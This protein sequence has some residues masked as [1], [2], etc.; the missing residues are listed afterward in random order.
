VSEPTRV[1]SCPVCR[2]LDLISVECP[3]GGHA[4]VKCRT[5][6]HVTID[7]VQGCDEANERVQMESFGDSFSRRSGPFVALYDSINA[8]RLIRSLD[9]R[10][11]SRVLEIGPGSGAVLDALAKL[12][13][14]V[15]G[16]DLSPAI[17]ERI[18][19]DFAIPVLIGKLETLPVGDLRHSFDVVVMRQVLEHFTDPR[20]ALASA[21]SLLKPNGKIYVAV[22]N[23]RSWQARFRG[24]AGYA[25]Y[26]VQ[27]FD[28]A[29]LRHALTAESF[30]VTYAES[31]EPISSWPNTLLRS[32]IG[33]GSRRNDRCG[34]RGDPLA[35]K[36]ILL[37]LSRLAAGLAIS[38]LRWLQA[39]LGFGDELVVIARAR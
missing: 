24:W 16:L 38:P 34:Y 4:L 18:M 26:H 1:Q 27:Y 11:R 19:S 3:F 13:H 33:G 37:E 39:A 6:G 23:M 12:G 31:Y 5:C 28:A 9:L 14:D 22:P 32:L 17:A 7:G 25:D 36:R 30:T 10:S 21:A 35:A 8:R 15:V 2:R 20:R 29:S